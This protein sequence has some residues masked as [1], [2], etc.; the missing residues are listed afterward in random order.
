MVSDILV[1]TYIVIM[2]YI[3]FLKPSTKAPSTTISPSTTKRM[4]GTE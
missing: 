1:N 2:P 3:A 4:L